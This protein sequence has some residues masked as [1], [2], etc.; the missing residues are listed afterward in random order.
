MIEIIDSL[1]PFACHGSDK[2]GSAL[3][4]VDMPVHSAPEMMWL[5]IVSFLGTGAIELI[6]QKWGY[7]LFDS[8]KGNVPII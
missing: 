5:L 3:W 4:K 2:S 1:G 7:V 8:F 6:D